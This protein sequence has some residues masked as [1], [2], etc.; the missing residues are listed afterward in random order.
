MRPEYQLNIIKCGEN[1]GIYGPEEVGGKGG[2]L[3]DLYKAAQKI[4]TFNVPEFFI[5]PVNY[6]HT[7]HHDI[8]TGD[9][10]FN[11]QTD[12][13]EKIFNELR[14]PVAVRSSSPLEDRTTASFA[15]MFSSFLDV[16]TFEDVKK[17]LAR[18][19]EGSLD[20]RVKN[21]AEKM[22]VE[23]DN[24]MAYIVQEQVTEPW[25]K[26]IIQLEEEKAVIEAVTRKGKSDCVDVEYEFLEQ[27]APWNLPLKPVDYAA[28]SVYFNMVESAI[29]AKKELYLEGL[30]QVEF[31]FSPGKF[32][33]PE[34]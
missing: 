1:P 10:Y 3:I 23:F 24:S 30:V 9:T 21:Y 29:K 31:C 25:L 34:K 27:H 4:G 17:A 16:N 33:C 11:F 2:H 18:I 15:G 13:V 32:Q 5:I 28:E 14:K 12:E 8:N 20:D 6:P 26:G 7:T 22:G 19:K